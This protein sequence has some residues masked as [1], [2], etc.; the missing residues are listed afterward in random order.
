MPQVRLLERF[1][2]SE[3]TLLTRYPPP[4]D[5]AKW[6]AT[7]RA[8]ALEILRGASTGTATSYPRLNFSTDFLA[9]KKLAD[10]AQLSPLAAKHLVTQ[11]AK[12]VWSDLLGETPSSHPCSD[13]SGRNYE[14]SLRRLH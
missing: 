5:L 7:V 10:P 9:G 2:M 8:P 3:N 11:E 4:L 1:E 14:A 6:D 13:Q 12:Y